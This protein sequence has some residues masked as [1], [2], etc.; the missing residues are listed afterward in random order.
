MNE[1][2]LIGID[3]GK[4]IFHLHEQRERTLSRLAWRCDC[5]VGSGAGIRAAPARN[6]E[7]APG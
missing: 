7:R 1:V 4:H 6:E 5:A 3:L 2:T